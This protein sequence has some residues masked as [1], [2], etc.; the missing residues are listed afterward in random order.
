MVKFLQQANGNA[1]ARVGALQQALHNG[2]LQ[3]EDPEVY[4]RQ[5]DDA[6]PL[7]PEFW[8]QEQ[9]AQADDDFFSSAFN[10]EEYD[11]PAPATPA[12]VSVAEEVNEPEQEEVVSAPAEEPRQ[13]AA[14]TPP[15]QSPP[16]A[17]KISVAEENG[18]PSLNDRF[19]DGQASKPTL[20]DKLKKGGSIRNHISLNQRFMFVKELFGG[21]GQMFNQALDELDRKASLAEAD[22]YIQRDIAGKY[23]WPVESEAVLEFQSVLEKR[24]G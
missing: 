24:F 16:K 4:L 22:H 9:S 2:Q 11:Q 5:L 14:T 17:P 18:R 3:T 20:S 7:P 12:S 6:C 10:E 19:S 23:G 8:Q 13:P 21:D 1:S 15:M